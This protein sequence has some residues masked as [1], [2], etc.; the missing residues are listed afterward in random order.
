M[1]GSWMIQFISPQGTEYTV[2]GKALMFYPVSVKTAFKLKGV[3]KPI[4]SALT[5]LFQKDGPLKQTTVLDTVEGNQTDIQPLS[6]EAAKFIQESH[7]SAAQEIF[8]TL[9]NEK[10]LLVIGELIMDSLRDD[11]KRHPAPTE[12]QIQEFVDSLD[13]EVIAQM[14]IG[15]VKANTKLFHPLRE[16]AGEAIKAAKSALPPEVKNSLGMKEPI[17]M[18]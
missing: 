10:T 6:I 14:A 8:D 13:L 17:G 1:K 11:Y 7:S 16:W 12:A 2:A 5:K 4:A 9:T 18:N 15:V 3:A